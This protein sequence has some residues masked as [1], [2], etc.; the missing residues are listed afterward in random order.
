M[1]AT[2]TRATPAPS[3]RM[4][5]RA[6]NAAIDHG[7]KI[8]IWSPGWLA[9]GILRTEY[10]AV[11]HRI[12]GYDRRDEVEPYMDWSRA[13]FRPWTA[14]PDPWA[15]DY[16]PAGPVGET[17]LWDH[18]AVTQLLINIPGLT[19]AWIQTAV[20]DHLQE[21]DAETIDPGPLPPL[22]QHPGVLERLAVAL[23]RL[24]ASRP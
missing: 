13:A 21:P 5:H 14:H 20:D 7:D 15:A 24:Q 17:W 16:P 1:T 4:L 11:L 12:L 8:V 18:R 22:T 6:A 10:R 9:A 2:L 19:E 3:I 23:D